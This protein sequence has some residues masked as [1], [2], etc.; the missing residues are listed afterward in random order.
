M[1]IMKIKMRNTMR[2]LM[3]LWMVACICQLGYGQRNVDQLFKT[4]RGES[5]VTSVRI[6]SFAMRLA[7]L[8]TDTYGV[9]GVDVLALDDCDGAVKE[10]FSAAECHASAALEISFITQYLFYKVAR[11]RERA[12]RKR[13]RVGVVAIGALK[14]ATLKEHGIANARSVQ[15]RKTLFRMNGSL[16]HKLEW[17][18]R[19][20]TSCCCSRLSL[21]KLTA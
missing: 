14:G 4:F 12:A 19:L 1:R 7:S 15:G 18:V 21:L 2:K 3:M 8:F 9:R 13:L 5:D 6:G 16:H 11:F 20:M 17:K 10:R